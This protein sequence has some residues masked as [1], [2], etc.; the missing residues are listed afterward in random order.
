MSIEAAFFGTLGRDAERKR[1]DTGKEFVRLTVRIGDGDKVQWVSVI[2]F[3]REIIAEAE[4]L[5]KGTRVYIEGRLSLDEWTA[6]DG[7]K[8]SGLSVVTWHCRPTHI[9]QRRLERDRSF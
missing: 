1:S 4:K 5:T 8:R 2:A 9:G 7:S 6:S 3:E